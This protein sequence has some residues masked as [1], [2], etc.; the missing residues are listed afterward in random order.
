MPKISN[1]YAQIKKCRIIK[2]SSKHL[3]SGILQ[4]EQVR[5]GQIKKIYKKVVL[6]IFL[7]YLLFWKSPPANGEKYPIADEFI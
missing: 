2:R 5:A 7:F 3:Y 4:K 1:N 6:I